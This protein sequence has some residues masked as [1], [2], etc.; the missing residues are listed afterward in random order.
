MEDAI[1]DWSDVDQ[2]N[3]ASFNDYLEKHETTLTFYGLF[4]KGL[5][6]K[7]THDVQ[8]DFHHTIDGMRG[9]ICMNLQL[10]RNK[11]R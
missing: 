5:R 11:I 9:I 3:A 4:P 7:G 1:S 2:W 10:F 6:V 8:N